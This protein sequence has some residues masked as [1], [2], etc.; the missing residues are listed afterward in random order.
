MQQISVLREIGLTEGEINVYYALFE[1]GETTVGPIS[2]ISG[3]THAKV[4]PILE[5]LI[6]KGLVSKIIKDKTMYFSPNTP[7]ALLDFISTKMR[8]LVEEKT[9]IKKLIPSLLAK[10]KEKGDFQYAKVIE[11]FKGIKAL[12]EDLYMNATS[13]KEVLVLGLDD[14]LKVTKGFQKFFVE[15]HIMRLK[16]KIHFKLVFRKNQKKMIDTLYKPIADFSLGEIR[17][18]DLLFP[19]GVFIFQDH[20]IT[21]LSDEKVTAFDIKSKQNADRYRKFFYSIWDS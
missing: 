1:L 7:N 20:V 3:V 9:K 18:I 5:R 15:Y 12:F 14:Q 10:Q 11:G 21:I 19:A 17:Y 13:K 4:Y 8:S 6:N 2:N 16:H